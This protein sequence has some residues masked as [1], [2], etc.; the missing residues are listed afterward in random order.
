[1]SVGEFR[2]LDTEPSWTAN[3]LSCRLCTEVSMTTTSW[4]Q[5]PCNLQSHQVT[6]FLVTFT[7][8][9]Y[10]CS[11]RPHYM[12]LPVPLFVCLFPIGFL[13]ENE[14]S[15]GK[16]KLVCTFLLAGVTSVP[17]LNSNGQRSGLELIQISLLSGIA[18]GCVRP[19]VCPQHG[20]CRIDNVHAVLRSLQRREPRRLPACFICV[21]LWNVWRIKMH[22]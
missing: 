3:T 17:I 7:Y 2:A 9:I 18:C 12:V 22:I 1:M 14:R 19:S 8:Y 20:L 16:P 21:A 13:L 6:S 10:G 11:N 4:L 15:V 5:R